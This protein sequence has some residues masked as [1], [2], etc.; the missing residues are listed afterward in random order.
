LRREF[1]GVPRMMMPSVDI[2]DVAQAHII[3][4]EKPGLSGKRILISQES[5]WLSEIAKILDEE[6]K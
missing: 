4:L 6:F 1:P 5:L 2:K 3:A